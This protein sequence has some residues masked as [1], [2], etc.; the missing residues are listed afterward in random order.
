[1]ACYL[2]GNYRVGISV[3]YFFLSYLCFIFNFI[4]CLNL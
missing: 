4:I 3:K 2:R 1:M